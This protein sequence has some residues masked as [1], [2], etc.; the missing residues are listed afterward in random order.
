VRARIE[1]HLGESLETGYGAI[2][3]RARIQALA[4]TVPDAPQ[5]AALARRDPAHRAAFRSS[6][7]GLRRLDLA[8]TRL[9]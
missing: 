4:V 6:A 5:P 1:R 3:A 2:G 8:G 7:A 9:A